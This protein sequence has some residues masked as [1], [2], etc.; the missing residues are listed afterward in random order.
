MFMLLA[1][2]SQAPTCQLAQGLA[3]LR[4]SDMQQVQD[5][6]FASMLQGS[7]ACWTTSVCLLASGYVG[8]QWLC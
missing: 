6:T 1:R 4:Q 7:L 3:G 5:L 2:H 8:R